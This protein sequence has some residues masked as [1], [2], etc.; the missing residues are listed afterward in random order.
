MNSS[1][2][3]G[4]GSLRNF[5]VRRRRMRGDETPLH[6]VNVFVTLKVVKMYRNKYL[7]RINSSGFVSSVLCH[8]S[9]SILPENMGEPPVF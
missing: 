5:G 7:F 8:W 9:L 3:K 4:F 2:V 1:S 6:S